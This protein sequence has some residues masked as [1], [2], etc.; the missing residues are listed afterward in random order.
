M[1]ESFVE[2]QGLDE[3]VKKLDEIPE[4]FRLQIKSGMGVVADKVAQNIQVTFK[5]GVRPGFRDQTGALR[6]SIKGGLSEEM[7]QGDAVVGFVGAGDDSPGSDGRPTREYVKYV[8]FGE[9][10]RKRSLKSYT[11][12]GIEALS[13]TRSTSF[14]RAGVQMLQRDIGVMLSEQVDLEKLV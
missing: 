12:K 4:K 6:A 7:S 14:L 3:L 11:L 13:Q 10:I 2:V 9:F 8:E 5:G 1:A